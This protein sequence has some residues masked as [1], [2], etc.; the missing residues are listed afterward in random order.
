MV[1]DKGKTREEWLPCR[2]IGVDATDLAPK[3]IVEVR[4]EDGEYYVDRADLIRKPAPGS[5][6]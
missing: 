2:V 1:F 5:M 4:T 6:A 3:F